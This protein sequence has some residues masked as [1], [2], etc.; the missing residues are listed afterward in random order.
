MSYEED[1][2]A[3]MATPQVSRP[4]EDHMAKGC[5]TEVKRSNAEKLQ[6]AITSMHSVEAHLEDL[7]GQI[8]LTCNPVNANVEDRSLSILELLET[9]PNAISS[10]EERLHSSIVEISNALR[11]F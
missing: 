10:L 11:G 1:I 9:A 4:M 8:G 2:R 5:T 3:S 6:S 7:K